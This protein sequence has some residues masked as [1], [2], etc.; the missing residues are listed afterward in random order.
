MKEKIAYWYKY[1]LWSDSMV[2]EAV[3]KTLNGV[4]F[5]AEDYKAITG[6]E[7]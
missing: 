6:K 7:Y 4:E 5:T 1:G 2:R 3:G